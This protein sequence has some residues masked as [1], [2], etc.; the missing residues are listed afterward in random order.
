MVSRLVGIDPGANGALACWE[1]NILMDVAD[2]PIALER[3]KR[4]IDAAALGALLR[5]FEPASIWMEQV[6]AMPRQ[7]VSST[8]AFGMAYG[9]VLGV[10]GALAIPLTAVAPLAWK[11][12]LRVPSAKGEARARASQLIPSGSQWWQRAKDDGRAEAALIGLYGVTTTRQV[13]EW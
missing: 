6:H 5:R 1:G 2:M 4:R 7:G 10:A 8:F 12:A 13:H 11:R 9:I 3:K